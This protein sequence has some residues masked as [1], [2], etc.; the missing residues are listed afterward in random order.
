MKIYVLLALPLLL[1]ADMANAGIVSNGSWSPT[2]CG[3]KPVAPAV[4][5][6]DIDAFNKSIESINAW[7]KSAKTYFD[8]LV[9]EANSPGLVW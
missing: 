5:D 3:E 1:T 7:K 2:C 6:S 8:C 9:K 4:N